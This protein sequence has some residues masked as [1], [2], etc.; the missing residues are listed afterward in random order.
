M[1]P[2]GRL[3]SNRREELT[4]ICDHMQIQPDN[5]LLILNQDAAREFLS[6]ST[7][8]N[9]YKVMVPNPWRTLVVQT[10]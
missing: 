9:R 8:E 3:V 5:P 2:A 1:R 10:K 4:A 7:A 6:S